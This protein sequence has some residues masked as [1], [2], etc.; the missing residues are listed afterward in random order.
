MKL[1]YCKKCKLIS[2]GQCCKES[3]QVLLSEYI[4]DLETKIIRLEYTLE[5]VKENI[6]EVTA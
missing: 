6:E 4:K 1:F 3:D 2:N 5:S